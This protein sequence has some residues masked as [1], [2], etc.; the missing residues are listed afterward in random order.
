[1]YYFV[2]YKKYLNKDRSLN[3]KIIYESII[4]FDTSKDIC[5]I[6]NK[7]FK[8]K[9]VDGN[10]FAAKFYLAKRMLKVLDNKKK[11]TILDKKL[12]VL[13]I[14]SD[15]IYFNKKLVAT[16]LSD[17]SQLEDILIENS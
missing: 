6:I 8:L 13:K 14:K 2:L 15:K 1:M 7:Y 16:T 9:Y 10:I 4:L 17:I 11:K 12:I 3:D 5:K